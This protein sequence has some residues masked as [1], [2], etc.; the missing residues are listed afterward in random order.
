MKTYIMLWA[1]MC[2]VLYLLTRSSAEP[3]KMAGTIAAWT[4]VMGVYVSIAWRK[5][6]GARAGVSSKNSEP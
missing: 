4:I 1:V 2:V 3:Y 6:R 5:K